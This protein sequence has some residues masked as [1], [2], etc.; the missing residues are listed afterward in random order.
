[1][2]YCALYQFEREIKEYLLSNQAAASVTDARKWFA[3]VAP[4]LTKRWDIE[5]GME[6]APRLET[7]YFDATRDYVDWYLN[8][9]LLDRPLL[10]VLEVHVFN[11]LLTRWPGI[12]YN[13]QANYDYYT[14]PLTKQYPYTT[15][16]GIPYVTPWNPYFYNA[17]LTFIQAYLQCIRVYGWW[18]YREYYSLDGWHASG[19]TVLDSGGIN[20]STT[21]IEVADVNGAQFDGET[22][23][24][25]PG[26][27]IGITTEDDTEIMEVVGVTVG[28]SPANDMITV[29][30]GQRGTVARSHPEDSVINIFYPQPEVVKAFTRWM[31]Y[32]Y[33][34][35]GIYESITVNAA[36]TYASV[37]PQDMPEE[38]WH[39]VQT[40][41]NQMPMRI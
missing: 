41:R 5:C 30:R 6:F 40:Y 25:S 39:V 2:A 16:Q 15:L 14:A 13:T 38:S 23:R 3:Q 8:Q 32:A 24:F 11:T 9:V 17:N 33:N 37:M 1:M 19:D 4:E 27:W 20:A 36:N 22:P 35:R 21:T 31:A 7:R 12:D 29:V 28:E 10:D 34:R 18:G 26:Q